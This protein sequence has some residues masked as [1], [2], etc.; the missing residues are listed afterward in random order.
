VNENESEGANLDAGFEPGR[1]DIIHVNRKERG[2]YGSHLSC[3]DNVLVV[4]FVSARSAECG[5]SASRKRNHDQ[6][7]FLFAFLKS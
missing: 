5:F 4:Y 3:F 6:L 2:G 1:G 7:Y